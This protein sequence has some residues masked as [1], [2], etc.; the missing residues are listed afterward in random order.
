[1]IARVTL[2]LLLSLVLL[3]SCRPSNN[4]STNSSPNSSSSSSVSAEAAILR[5]ELSED[6]SLGESPI[7]VFV[8]ADGDGV[9]GAEIEITG[10][11][12]HAG[13]VPVIVNAL[14]V[15]PGLYRAEDFAFSMAG[16]WIITTEVKLPDGKK[17]MDE[18]K[19]TVSSQ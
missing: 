14:E 5:V 6:P 3:S 17:M 9:S 18:T 13:M 12:T 4:S 15:E 1:M 19:V 10:D 7:A 16:D 11:M 8:L 2:I